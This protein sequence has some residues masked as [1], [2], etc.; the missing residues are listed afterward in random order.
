MMALQSITVQLPSG[1]YNRLKRR[2]E[3]SQRSIEAEVVEAV[4]GALPADDELSPELSRAVASLATS[5]DAALWRAVK[6]QFP[7]DKS[8]QLERIHMRS[9]AGIA[10]DAEARQAAELAA[11]LERF[12]FLRAQAMSFLMQRGH[13]LSTLAK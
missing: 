6:V 7:A 4:A 3:K 2:A 10:T 9:Q 11:E 8:A 12:M 13:D 5:D 1:L